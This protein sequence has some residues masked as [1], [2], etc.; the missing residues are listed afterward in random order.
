MVVNTP[1]A[2]I[3]VCPL[4]VKVP[5]PILGAKLNLKSGECPPKLIVTSSG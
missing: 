3:G 5:A 4:M 1:L 2:N